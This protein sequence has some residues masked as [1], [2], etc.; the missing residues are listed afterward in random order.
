MN[1]RTTQKGHGLGID[2]KHGSWVFIDDLLE[3]VLLG[4]LQHV[5]DQIQTNTS[6]RHKNLISNFKKSL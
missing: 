1:N 2:F 6:K 5:L 3:K 4:E